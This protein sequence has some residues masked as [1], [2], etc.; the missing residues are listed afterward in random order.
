MAMNDLSFNQI[1]TVLN[2]VVEQA[3]GKKAITPTNTSDF[4][5]VAQ[6]GLKTGYDNVLNAI[7]QVLSRTIFSVR[8]Y[9]R[10]LAGLQ[11]SNDRYGN[12][13]RKLQMIDGEFE[14]DERQPLTDETAVDMYKVK[15]PKVLQTNFYG[16]TAYQDHITI[17]RDQLD[18]AF[19]SPDEF[20]RF[21]SM[22]LQNMSDR[23][24]Q[25]NESLARMTVANLIGGVVKIS[26][27]NTNQVVHLLTEYNAAT[28]GSYTATTI[29]APE[30]YKAFSQ[31]AY[32]RVA[33]ITS[34]LTE[35][36]QVYHQNITGKEVSR[37][38][39]FDRQ[40]VYLYAP[41]QYQ[42]EAMV[43]SDT[44]HDNYIRFADN[45]RLNFW[46]SI[47][48]GAS[49]N[50]NATYLDKDGS[51]K[52]E[53]IEQDNIFGVIMDEEAAGYTVVNQWSSPTPFNAA[54]GYSNLFWHW[55]DRYWN[56]FTENCVVLLMD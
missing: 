49:I 30:A 53:D 25:A 41:N 5:A 11:V 6:L 31:W 51:L 52:S 13:V 20:W 15:K 46:Q 18:V 22:T 23:F 9:S 12:H 32:A 4:V 3:T 19:S 24:E 47:D 45:E 26:E 27:T 21:I 10:K 8:P 44:Y 40:R 48:K 43:L 14:D 17:F 34:M 38:T 7:S 54:G 42:I 37:H 29:M 56:D 2:T 39:P 50:V 55:T 1:S 33:Q 36:T 28:G 16:Q 35:R